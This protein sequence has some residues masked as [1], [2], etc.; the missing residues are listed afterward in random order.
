MAPGTPRSD[1][2]VS[3]AT[4]STTRNDSRCSRFGKV[5]ARLAC[6]PYAPCAIFALVALGC[7]TVFPGLGVPMDRFV[8]YLLSFAP[9]GD[10]HG[11]QPGVWIAAASYAVLAVFVLFVV[12]NCMKACGV[13]RACLAAR[14]NCLFVID[15]PCRHT[16]H[17]ALHFS[18]CCP[19]LRLLRAPGAPRSCPKRGNLCAKQ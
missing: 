13:S 19:M 16:A 12:G 1:P 8:S 10:D 18:V 2:R 6:I 7:T 11:V 3:F 4:R 14:H 15:S 9:A 5:C 17:R